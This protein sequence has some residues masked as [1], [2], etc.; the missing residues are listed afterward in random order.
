MSHFC[1]KCG[2]TL[3]DTAFYK[4]RNVEKY[5]PDGKLNMCKECLTMH[6]NN[7]DEET[8]KWILEEIDV[9]Y[10]KEWWDDILKKFLETKSP[11]KLKGTSIL[12]KYLSKLRIRQYSDYR[13]K[14]T[15]K[16][17]EEFR[18]KKINSMQAQGMTEEEITEQLAVNT[19][20][21][22]PK[23]DYSPVMAEDAMEE[24][25]DEFAEQLTEEDKIYLKLKWGRG[26]SA[27]EWVRLEQLYR[28]MENSYDIQGAGMRDT[29]IMICKASLKANQLVDSADYD[30]FSK[31]TKVYNDLMKSAKL[32]AAQNKAESNDFIDSIGELV[33]ICEKDGFIP[34]YYIDSPKDKADRVIQDMQSY[35]HDLVVDELGLGQMIENSVKALERERER[36]AAAAKLGEN[37]EEKQEEDLFRESDDMLTDSDIIEFKESLFEEGED[38]ES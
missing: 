11:E 13:W 38:E 7:W 15:E 18:Q 3:A 1:I 24:E 5:P 35:T 31:M 16:L 27:E 26:Y 21:P 8:Y 33:A 29:L 25:Q 6:V 17:A 12:G 23:I 37:F 9:P 34:R 14:D 2:K 28:D 19:T 36:I 32:T 20:P 4:S 22:R 30:G 10:V